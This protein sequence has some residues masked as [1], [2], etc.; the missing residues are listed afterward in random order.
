VK[1][2]LQIANE[3]FGNIFAAG[4]VAEST[5][6]MNGLSAVQQAMTVCENIIRAI[7]G[8]QLVA[9]K[10]NP[11]LEGGIELTLGMVSL[12]NFQSTQLG[13]TT[14]GQECDLRHGRIQRYAYQHEI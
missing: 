1:E 6:R 10:A 5:G 13:L 3:R 9:H 4:D 7:N 2:S 11:L 8:R 12:T 14:T